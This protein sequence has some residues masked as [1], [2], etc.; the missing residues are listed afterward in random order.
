MIRYLQG[1]G[2]GLAKIRSLMKEARAGRVEVM[3]SDVNVAEV[4]RKLKEVLR[5]QALDLLLALRNGGVTIRPSSDDVIREVIRANLPLADAYAFA[6]AKVT[7]ARLWT[8]DVGDLGHARLL[9]EIS[10]TLFPR[11]DG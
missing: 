6:T 11:G 7:R 5:E 4:G 10:V 3:M 2:P 1:A 9:K 8:T